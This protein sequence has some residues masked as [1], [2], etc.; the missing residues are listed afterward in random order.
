[1]KASELIKVAATS[2][3]KVNRVCMRL[4]HR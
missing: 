2:A 1:V 4:L 3:D